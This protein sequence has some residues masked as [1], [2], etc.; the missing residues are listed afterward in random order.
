[1]HDAHSNSKGL[2]DF[3]FAC[4]SLQTSQTN[5]CTELYN[6]PEI[7]MNSQRTCISCLDKCVC[8]ESKCVCPESNTTFS[9]SHRQNNKHVLHVAYTKTNKLD[10]IEALKKWFEFK[11]Y[12]NGALF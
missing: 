12:S 6:C 3:F 10:Y 2:I 11:F 8:P 7:T 5:F 4:F 1:M 9:V